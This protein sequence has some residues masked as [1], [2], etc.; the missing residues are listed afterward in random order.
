MWGYGWEGD[1][2]PLGVK[3]LAGLGSHSAGLREHVTVDVQHEIPAGRVLHHKAYVVWSLE[4][5][6]QVYQEGVSRVGHSRQNPLLTHQAGQ[7]GGQG[8]ETTAALYP[9]IAHCPESSIIR[10][11]LRA[12]HVCATL[13]KVLNISEPQ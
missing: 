3:L 6:K 2:Q 10:Y 13:G 8:S 1:C 5:A 9:Q 7:G 12:S 11:L 4:T